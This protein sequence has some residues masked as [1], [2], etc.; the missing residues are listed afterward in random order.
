MARKIGAGA[1]PLGQ[2]R[3]DLPKAL[4]KLVGRALALEPRRRPPADRLAAAL[5]QAIAPPPARRRAAAPTL[6]KVD[7]HRFLAP[8]LAA[9]LAGWS[10]AALPFYPAGWP[11]GLAA[12][13]GGLT[14]LYPRAGLALALALPLFP[15][16]NVALGLALLYGAVAA[17][18]LAFSWR[19]PRE[20]FAPALGPLLAPVGLLALLPLV[21]VTVR[22][23][24]RRA[25][26]AA[27]AGVLAAIV[28]GIRRS[29]LP[30]T[31]EG[32]PLVPLAGI[33]APQ[34]AARRL[35]EAVP[36]V[37]AFELLVL[38][39]ATAL[40]PYAARRGPWGL[41]GFGA[42]ALAALLLPDPSVAALPVVAAVWITCGALALNRE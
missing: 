42:I 24:T 36:G 10:T 40:L 26:Y 30:L 28:A 39:A 18:W 12:L 23:T 20:A 2:A 7:V 41:A 27:V 21:L 37:F 29:P 13:A 22:G 3:P 15:L 31:G 34:E 4:V 19:S 9:L 25:L 11:L 6:P 16:G 17:A 8:L 38:A 5:R 35:L 1:P 33:E 14:A 32:P